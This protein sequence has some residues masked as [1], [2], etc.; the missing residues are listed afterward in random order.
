MSEPA[1]T[2][3][4]RP[5][6]PDGCTA[7]SWCAKTVAGATRRRR[8]CPPGSFTCTDLASSQT[9]ITES[10]S[11]ARLKKTCIK[12]GR[13]SRFGNLPE[14][15]ELVG[16]ERRGVQSWRGR[17]RL[18]APIATAAPGLK[19]TSVNV[20]FRPKATVQ[21]RYD[22]VESSTFLQGPAK[23]T[24]LMGSILNGFCLQLLF[25]KTAAVQ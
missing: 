15:I 7:Q 22:V 25:V 19:P 14:F 24:P 6:A 4:A 13:L 10:D 17:S 20:D 18:S 16:A 12:A 3:P 11:I 23:T 21:A 9:T 1:V 2:W 5:A 8:P